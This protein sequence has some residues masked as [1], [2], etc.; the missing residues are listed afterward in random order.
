MAPKCSDM[1]HKLLL[2]APE[3]LRMDPKCTEG[4]PDDFQ[5]NV[6]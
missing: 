2:S 6:G 3:G 5:K 1:A 4:A